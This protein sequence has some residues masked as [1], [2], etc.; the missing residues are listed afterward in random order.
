MAKLSTIT[1]EA[2][3]TVVIVS[4]SSIIFGLLAIVWPGLT[5]VFFAR[6]F[7]AFGIIV[8][9]VGL[10][11]SLAAIQRNPLW[12]LGMLFAL[13]NIVLAAYLFHE[14]KVTAVIFATLL[15]IYVVIQSL[16]D[17]VMASFAQKKDHKSMWAITGILGFIAAAII[18]F[19]PVA[20]SVAFA[21]VLG[22]Y[23]FIHGIVGLSY[24]F[25]IR[26]MMGKSLFKK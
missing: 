2:W 5:L 1:K 14:P 23:A 3:W 7:A 10:L 20:V 26:R 15:A 17:L 4:A 25:Q 16:I 6:L 19:Y 22:M 21:W 13:C 9:F 18:A 24:A 12:W 8:G 11:G